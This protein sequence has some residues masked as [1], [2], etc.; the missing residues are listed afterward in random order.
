MLNILSRLRHRYYN[1]YKRWA[2]P[3]KSYVRGGIAIRRHVLIPLFCLI[4]VSSGC[5]KRET[6]PPVP[7]A[8]QEPNQGQTE[9]CGLLTKGEIEAIQGSPIKETKSSARS[10]AAFRVSQCF[11][12]ATEFSKSVSVAVMQRDPGRPTTTSP[13]DFWKEGFGRYSGNEKERDKDKEET[14]RK[15][16]KEESVPPKK[17]EGIGEE[18]FWASNRFG[19][20]LYILK[21]DAFISIS[22]GGSENEETKIKKSKALAQKALQRL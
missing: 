3:N 12:T 6:P 15:E 2:K 13:K 7:R 10:D 1:C 4:L 19:G 11:Y 18:A 16:E 22:L 21:G 8:S 5:K 9:V 20:V 17:I 14:E